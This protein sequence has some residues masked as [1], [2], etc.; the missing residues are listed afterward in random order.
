VELTPLQGPLQEDIQ[1]KHYI[2]EGFQGYHNN[3]WGYNVA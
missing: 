2:D 1:P 3:N